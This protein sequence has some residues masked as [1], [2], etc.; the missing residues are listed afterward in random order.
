MRN[1]L[2]VVLF[3]VSCSKQQT[4]ETDG[5]SFRTPTNSIFYSKGTIK[6]EPFCTRKLYTI[7]SQVNSS[8]ELMISIVTDKLVAGSYQGG[9]SHWSKPM[10]S[11]NITLN[12]ISFNDGV[13]NAT[14]AG[15]LSSGIIKNIHY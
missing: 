11:D 8:E 12:V 1:L 13:L 7:T 3:L 6:A 4:G 15:T 2:I 10:L 9:L 5:I 14:F